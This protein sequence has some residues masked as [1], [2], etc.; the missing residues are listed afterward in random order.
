MLRAPNTRTK[1]EVFWQA[2]FHQLQTAG[3]RPQKL[4]ALRLLWIPIL[5]I[6]LSKQTTVCASE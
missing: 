1:T 3:E 2:T 5:K 6:N 4:G